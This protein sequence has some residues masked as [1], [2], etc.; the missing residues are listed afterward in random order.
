MSKAAKGIICG[1]GVDSYSL[2]I[3]GL[4]GMIGA[5]KKR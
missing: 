2:A 3:V 5:Q 1:F 4:A